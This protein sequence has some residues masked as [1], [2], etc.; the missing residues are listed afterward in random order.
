VNRRTAA[1][2]SNGNGVAARMRHVD[3]IVGD[4][5]KGAANG[6]MGYECG[7]ARRSG[8]ERSGK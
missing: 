6:V 4:E 3:D 8:G 7:H 5:G 2:S 1:S